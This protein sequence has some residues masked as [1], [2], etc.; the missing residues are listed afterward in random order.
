M[1]LLARKS[2]PMHLG[3]HPMEKIRRVDTPT[4]LIREDQVERVPKRADGFARALHGDYGPRPQA[5]RLA[6]GGARAAPTERV[7]PM[8][9]AIGTMLREMTKMHDGPVRPDKAPIPNDPQ[10]LAENIKSLCYF[11]DADAVGICEAKPYAWYSHDKDGSAIEPYHKNAIVLLIDQGYETLD[12]ASGDD[13]MSSPQSVRAYMRGA[14]IGNIVAHYIRELG[15]PAKVQSAVESDVMHL[16]L[17]LWAGLGELSRIGEV[18]LHP[19]LGPRFKSTV[20]TTD[21]PLAFDKPIDFG[22]QDFCEKCLKCAREC[23]VSAITFGPKIFYN[24]YETWKPDVQNC[25]GYRITNPRGQGCGRC[26]KMCPWNKVDFPLHNLGR[27]AAI[28]LPW[29]R[30]FLAWLDDRLG[31]G[32]RNLV[33]KWWFDLTGEKDTLVKPKSTNERDLQLDRKRSDKHRIALYRT[34]M[35][36]RADQMHE[37]PYD[38]REGLEITKDLEA[39]LQKELGK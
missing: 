12:G 19:F 15:Y 13:W 39:A 38:R 4:T 11:L 28:K 21:M 32:N 16:P 5:K 31:Y 1:G 35:L 36:P 25:T 37:V 2:R 29:T 22:L 14:E 8:S 24:G 3:P 34:D 10:S 20:I 33:K 27:W 6:T 17:V 18:V 23:P 26:L 30:R 9:L 7:Q